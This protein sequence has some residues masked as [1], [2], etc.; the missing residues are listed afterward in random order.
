[1]EIIAAALGLIILLI[2]GGIWLWSKGWLGE[3]DA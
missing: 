1:M 2:V 3:W